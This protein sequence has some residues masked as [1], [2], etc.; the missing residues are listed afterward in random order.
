MDSIESLRAQ[1]AAL[2]RQLDRRDQL[3]RELPQLRARVETLQAQ[4]P[5]LSQ[6]LRQKEAAVTRLEGSGLTARLYAM[7]GRQEA[8]LDAARQAA[9]AAR[10]ACHDAAAE[11]QRC[12]NQLTG[13]ETERKALDRVGDDY[14]R[15]FF[16]LRSLLADVPGVGAQ[17]AAAENRLA[18]VNA[19]LRRISA[20]IAAG[21]DARSQCNEVSHYLDN[22][23]GF[24]AW[25]LMGGST[26]VDLAKYSQLD[27][28][29]RAAD[30]LLD[31]LSRFRT[32]LNGLTAAPVLQTITVGGFLRF[33]DYFF[34]NPFTDYAVLSHIEHAR[35]EIYRLSGQLESALDELRRL[36]STALAEKQR[37][38]DA[39][40]AI[41][42][43]I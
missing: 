33:A 27:A 31:L 36:Q 11:Q 23:G 3:D 17:L 6:D 28:A 4:L 9:A 40:R 39:L 24:G 38:S 5:F 8:R 29:Q 20:S 41:V 34:D 32:E 10:R 42:A 35:S 15:V 25:D 1:L 43:G 12:Q 7:L 30:A 18:A 2:T 14:R 16:E 26:F 13:M 19:Q 37:A 22:A 21:Q